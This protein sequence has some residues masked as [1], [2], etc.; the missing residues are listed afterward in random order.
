MQ[1]ALD[2]DRL[3]L[4]LGGNQGDDAA[5]LDRF[6][7]AVRALAAWGPVHASRVYRTAPV[8]PAQPDYLNAA[9]ALTVP[10][11]L[12]ASALLREV[13]TIEYA[14]GRRRVAGEARWGPRPIDLDVLLWGT[15][16][17]RRAGAPLL[18]PHP[19]LARRRFALE[20]VIELVGRD[21]VLPGS[22]PALTL[23]AALDA[24]AAD[25]AQRLAATDHVIAGAEPVTDR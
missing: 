15:R 19:Q 7:G 22:E 20:P 1:L 23:G 5:V 3:I 17:L 2:D 11:E 4:G 9:L 10:E 13:Q 8:G 25:P 18:V 12:A 14:L 16:V 21:V 6:A 24:L